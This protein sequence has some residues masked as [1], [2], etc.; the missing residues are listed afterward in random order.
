MTQSAPQRIRCTVESTAYS[1]CGYQEGDA[2]DIVDGKLVSTP[3]S[4]ICLYIINQILGLMTVRPDDM[5]T[6]EWIRLERPM[7]TCSDGPER[8][9][10]R[11][12]LVED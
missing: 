3:K 1:M 2:F 12:S 10:V 11:L 8:T 5:T 6:E 4:G 7:T 9:V